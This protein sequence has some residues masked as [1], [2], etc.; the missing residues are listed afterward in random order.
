[1]SIKMIANN[2]KAR[3]NY[4]IL[5]VFEAGV[6]L[7]GTEVKSLRAGKINLDD[8]YAT[9]HFEELMWLNAN[10]PEY[11]HGNIHNH[12]PRR[13]RKLLMHR[14]EI[15]RLI[16]ITREKGLTLIP[17]RVYWKGSRVKVEIGVGKGKKLYDK[18]KTQETRDWQRDKERLLKEGGR[19]ED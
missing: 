6:A 10:I 17:T 14:R 4:E 8:S 18:R 12:D 1:M 5:E 11:S 9:V 16:G 3:F 7:E 15:K 13:S 19:G 2:R